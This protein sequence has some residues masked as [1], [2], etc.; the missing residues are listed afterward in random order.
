MKMD[1]TDYVLGGGALGCGWLAWVIFEGT[2]FPA[3]KR[4]YR[5]REGPEVYIDFGGR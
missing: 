3:P 2:A 1:V 4:T 5:G